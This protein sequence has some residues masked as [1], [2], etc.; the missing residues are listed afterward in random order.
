MDAIA[1][2]TTETGSFLERVVTH[3]VHHALLTPARRRELAR[4]VYEYHV[5]FFARMNLNTMSTNDAL[6]GGKW[7]THL[8]SLGLELETKGDMGRAVAFLAHRSPLEA[9]T[10]G[11]DCLMAL[12]TRSDSFHDNAIGHCL[13]ALW[14]REVTLSYVV[15]P[16]AIDHALKSSDF[17]LDVF[18]R[19][20]HTPTDLFA[21]EQLLARLEKELAVSK[22]FLPWN[23]LRCA[24][25]MTSRSREPHPDES[26]L[27]SL[28]F[29]WGVGSLLATI[30]M[31]LHMDR[32]SYGKTVIGWPS[33]KRFIPQLASSAFQKKTVKLAAVYLLK[34]APSATPEERA[35]LMDMWEW[36]LKDLATSMPAHGDGAAWMQRV[37]LTFGG[38][39]PPPV[40]GLRIGSE[41]SLEKRGPNILDFENAAGTVS[42]VG[43]KRMLAALTWNNL[44]QDDIERLIDSVR[45]VILASG[46]PFDVKIIGWVVE[47]WEEWDEADQRRLI[48]RLLDYAPTSFWSAVQ[49]PLAQRLSAFAS[50]VQKKRIDRRL[51]SKKRSPSIE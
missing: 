16:K 6:R 42:D 37:H 47:E 12:K 22:K 13:L 31:T 36:A 35:V 18:M 24:Y 46:V 40:A 19:K 2:R 26:D 20:I 32:R 11:V 34:K 21:F 9:L 49:A 30:G 44:L 5:P 28:H 33:F 38:R 25:G 4:L 51:T 7:M 15:D 10:R 43:I 23:E 29:D 17:D 48:E 14:E 27:S 39:E 1:V 8:L 45:P 50:G 3:G 41:D